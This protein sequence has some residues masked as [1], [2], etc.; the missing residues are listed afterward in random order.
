MYMTTLPM[1]FF[2]V[3]ILREKPFKL[4]GIAHP[5]SPAIAALLLP[6]V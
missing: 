3:E 4:L 5:L 6:S 1:D 2:F